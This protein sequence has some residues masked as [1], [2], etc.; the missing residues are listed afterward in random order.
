M[1]CLSSPVL[2]QNA[3]SHTPLRRVFFEIT[4][5]ACLSRLL[6]SV[7]LKDRTETHPIPS[8]SI[9]NRGQSV[10]VGREI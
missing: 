5:N 7:S 6:G 1:F 2:V 4:G 8:Y 3:N 10:S 9:T